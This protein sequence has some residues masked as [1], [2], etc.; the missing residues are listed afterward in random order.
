MALATVDVKVQ[1]RPK[2]GDAT[3]Y[4][5]AMLEILVQSRELSPKAG[6][7]MLSYLYEVKVGNN[8]WEPLGK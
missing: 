3:P 8:D 2:F 6:R 5:A 7:E 4:M 1:L